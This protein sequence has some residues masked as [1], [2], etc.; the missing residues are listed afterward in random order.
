MTEQ[1]I[2]AMWNSVENFPDSRG[3]PLP[4]FRAD[5]CWSV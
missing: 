2:L 4:I 3:L 5:P 1:Q